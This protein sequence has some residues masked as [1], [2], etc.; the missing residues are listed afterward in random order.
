M[1]KIRKLLNIRIMLIAISIC[2]LL[3]MHY[4]FYFRGFLEWTWMYSEI[5][6]LCGVLFDVSFLIILF[7]ILSRGRLKFALA[8]T[9][10]ITLFWSFVNVMYGK[11]FFQ[12]ISLSAIEEVHGLGDNLVIN[13]MLSAFCWYDFYYIFSFVLFI[14]LFRKIKPYT[15]KTRTI[16]RLLLVP[17]FSIVMT[18]FAYS[19][20]HFIHP[21]YRYN[22]ELYKFRSREF[23]F[24][25]VGG[26]TQNLAHFQT[27]CIRVA[28]FELYEMFHT[29]TLTAEQRKQIEDYYSDRT[30]RASNHQRNPNIRNV[31][32]ILLESFLSA[33]IDLKVDGIEVTPFLNSLRRDSTVYYNGNMVSDIGCGESGDGQF[34]YM[35]GILPLRHRMTVGQVKDNILPS[36]PKVL[37][38]SFGVK[39]SEIISPTA[40]NLWQQSEMNKAYGFCNAYWLEDITSGQQRPIDDE[41]IFKFASKRLEKL[42]EPFFSLV[43]SLSTHSPYTKYVGDNIMNGNRK[44]NELYKNYLNS[45]HFLDEQLGKYITELKK[46][47]LYNRSLIVIA[48]DHYAHLD[49]LG[50]K[51]QILD[52]TPLFIINGNINNDNSKITEIHQLDLYTSLLDLLQIKQLWLGLGHTVLIPSDTNSVNETAYDISKMIIEG[53]YFSI[54]D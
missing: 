30:S 6:N 21:H 25:S 13:S 20:Y 35:T 33:P 50:M 38:K 1:L 29:V 53:D 26:G 46:R 7:L 9:Q 3:F 11:F 52:Y 2:N 27:G 41:L 54:A 10:F 34:I 36:L 15:I 45:C 28:F 17:A 31:I 44:Y 5:I 42:K 12:Y 24:D 18:F 19:T 47:G 4:F 40:P 16:I 32:F 37:R 8:M 48:S 49:M 39:Y 51:D 22:W 23:L 14:F 43:L